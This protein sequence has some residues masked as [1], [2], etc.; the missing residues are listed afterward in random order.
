[1]ADMSAETRN[2]VL[3]NVVKPEPSE[4]VLIDTLENYQSKSNGFE[5]SFKRVPAY[6][7][8]VNIINEC[9]RSTELSLNEY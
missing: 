3:L 4:G 5:N 6:E 1:M 9:L 2:P 7:L 8:A